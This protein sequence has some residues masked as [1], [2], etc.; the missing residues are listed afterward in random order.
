MTDDETRDDAAP[1]VEDKPD[2]D[3]EAP[4]ATD[5]ADTPEKPDYFS[6]TFDPATLP[7]ELR[8]AYNQLRADY[9]QKTQ[10]VAEQRREVEQHQELLSALRSDDPY[11]R[12]QAL[13]YL[14]FSVAEEGDEEEEDGDEYQDPID[15][16]R[17]EIQEMKEWRESQAQ[18]AEES[19][20]EQAINADL[21]AQWAVLQKDTGRE[22]D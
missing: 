4:V 13:E 2:V 17:A 7:D 8:P 21:D 20:F 5:K 14:G 6:D 16:L 12:A 11:L 9:T 10:T 19:Q 1:E 22:F 3:V 18:S 15:A